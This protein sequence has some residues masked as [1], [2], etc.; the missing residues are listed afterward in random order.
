MQIEENKLCCGCGACE[1]ICPKSAI[2]M[3]QNNKG[4]Y[5]PQI[6]KLK[7]IECGMCDN[8]CPVFNHKTDN[9][10]KPEVYSFVSK[11][12]KTRLKSASGSV[13][14]VFAKYIIKN[15]GVVF[16]CVWDENITACHTKAETIQE[17]EKMYSSKYVQSNTKNTYSQAKEL[18]N[19]GRHVLYT[20]TPCQIAGLKSFL[21][22]D[23]DNLLTMEVIC[24][25]T[26]SPKVLEQYKNE[27]MKS[28]RKGEIL[29]NINFRS[30]I[31][32]WDINYL[33]TTT[34]TTTTHCPALKDPYM[35]CFLFNLSINESC[36]HCKFNQLPRTADITMGDFWGVENYDNSLNDKKGISIILINSQKGREY[37]D[38]IKKNCYTTSVPLDYVT[39]HNPNITGSSKPHPKHDEFF[40][41]FIEGKTSLKKLSKKYVKTYPWI[42][43][44]FYKL[45]PQNIKNLIKKY[46][47]RKADA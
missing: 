21:Q 9:D 15:G 14:P 23:Y 2:T 46:I 38:K 32:G 44:M 22:R 3:V 37:Y 34:T 10:P 28:K 26:P 6:D 12:E 24:H 18:L 39:K 47:L 5:I 36:I 40:K 17:L 43:R 35:K 33:L 4:F 20:G 7:C 45:M 8:I 25:G 19:S 1:N 29:E 11:D 16:G 31:K 30:K 41:E 13:F 27:F 42:L